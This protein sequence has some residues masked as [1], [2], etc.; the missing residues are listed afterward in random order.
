M[1]KG[2][3]SKF[4]RPAPGSRR[5]LL[6]RPALNVEAAAVDVFGVPSKRRLDPV[7]KLREQEETLALTGLVAA[8]R[9]TSSA[10]DA[11]R[12]ARERSRHDG[13]VRGRVAD[14]QLADSAHV[15]ALREVRDAE[16][17]A[18]AAAKQLTSAQG[19]LTAAHGRVEAVRKAADLR[20]LGAAAEARRREGKELDEIALLRHNHR[21]AT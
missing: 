21:R 8:R 11:L 10:E 18:Q 2:G 3:A 4:D 5:T 6:R 20:A 13:R 1:S 16:R 7:I 15:T 17:A 12:T 19:D 9:R 14:W